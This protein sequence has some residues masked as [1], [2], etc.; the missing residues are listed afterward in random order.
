M[1]AR[2]SRHIDQ[3]GKLDQETLSFISVVADP[4]TR[5]IMA[6]LASKHSPIA[7][8]AVP[9]KLLNASKLQIVSR[10]CRLER[11]GLVTSKRKNMEDDTFYKEYSINDNGR[12]LVDSH[13]SNE[14]S[15]FQAS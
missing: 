9:T 13:M 7:V 4:L 2:S 1:M 12:A 11:Q 14:L 3:M 8:D 10:L 5:R 15:K 6:K